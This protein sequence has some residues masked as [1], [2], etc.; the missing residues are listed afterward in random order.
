MKKYI[1]HVLFISVVCANAQTSKS[2][3]ETSNNDVVTLD[4]VNWGLLNPLRGDKSPA[5]GQLWGDRTETSASGFLVKFNTGFSSPPHIHNITYRG[6]VIYGAV[7]NA[8][9]NAKN[10]WLPTASYWQQPA[11]EPHITSA[12]GTTNLAYIEIEKGPYLVQ[13]K[14]DAFSTDLHSLNVHASNLVWLNASDINWIDNN[15]G[16]QS[17]AL[18]G[19]YFAGELH[20]SMLKIPAHFNGN[21]KSLCSVFRAVV[22]QGTI[23]HSLEGSTSS[24]LLEPGSYFGMV[25]NSTH[26]ISNTSDEAVILYIRSNGTFNVNVI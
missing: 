16:V 8:D 13:P 18:W 22:I 7:H 15:S 2:F 3:T 23:N 26:K 14:S 11:G 21:I 24:L 17:V 25:K 20:G 5:A 9:E 10:M 12:S 4:Q 1:L 6:V 19:N